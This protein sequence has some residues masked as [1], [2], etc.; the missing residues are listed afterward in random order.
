MIR[1]PPR[2]TLFPYT[3]L[4]RCAL[5]IWAAGGDFGAAR[6]AARISSTSDAPGSA[7]PDSS[8]ALAEGSFAVTGGEGGACGAG[9]SAGG[10]DG[11]GS[12]LA[13]AAVVA[14]DTAGA[15]GGAG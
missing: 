8:A 3:T 14:V 2:S 9:T 12:A 5:P 7:L 15:A 13:A 4:F 10:M 1:R 11:E 6:D